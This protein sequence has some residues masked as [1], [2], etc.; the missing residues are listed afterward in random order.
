MKGN[1]E[2]VLLL[3]EGGSQI[4]KARFLGI[5]RYSALDGVE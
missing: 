5:S 1:I 3:L 2:V 4:D